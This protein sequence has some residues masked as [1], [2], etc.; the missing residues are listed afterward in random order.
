VLLIV[1]FSTIVFRKYFYLK[2]NSKPVL[3][4]EN[5]EEEI[6]EQFNTSF[7]KLDKDIDKEIKVKKKLKKQEKIKLKN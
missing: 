6:P 3:Q 2:I 1:T 7:E 4:E 5:L